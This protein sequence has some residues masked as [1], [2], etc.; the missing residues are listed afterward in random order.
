MPYE[1]IKHLPEIAI[2][3]AVSIYL[4]NVVYN[5]CKLTAVCNKQEKL[6]APITQ[7]TEEKDHLKTIETLLNEQGKQRI[8]N[9]EIEIAAKEQEI[10]P[11]YDQL[12]FKK[13]SYAC[14]TFMT[15]P[16]LYLF[17]K[18]FGGKNRHKVKFS[19]I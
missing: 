1:I 14:R 4:V 7:L 2:G 3:G 17:L 6:L 15:K 9:L 8:T 5:A 10:K 13:G 12:D 19:E 18:C 11:K 16:G